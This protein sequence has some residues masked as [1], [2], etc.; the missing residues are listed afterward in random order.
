V[1]EPESIL[2]TMTITKK[3]PTVIDPLYPISFISNIEVKSRG[4]QGYI[5]GKPATQSLI[6]K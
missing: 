2:L 1:I 6:Y 5:W 3:A 4:S